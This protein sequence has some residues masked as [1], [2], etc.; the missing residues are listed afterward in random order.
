MIPFLLLLCSSWIVSC[1]ITV[2]SI[3]FRMRSTQSSYIQ[4]M[5]IV[6]ERAKCQSLTLE[7]WQKGKLD[8][9]PEY[10]RMEEAVAP[11]PNYYKRTFKLLRQSWFLWWRCVWLIFRKRSFECGNLHVCF[12]EPLQD[13]VLRL[14]ENKNLLKLVS[15]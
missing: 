5:G 2:F 14:Q 11:Y 13:R 6:R 9:N 3:I 10:C 1:K 7:P 12:M 8:Y 15:E 4:S